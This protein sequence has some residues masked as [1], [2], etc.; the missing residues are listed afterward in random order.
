[1][2]QHAP[3]SCAQAHTLAVFVDVV[4]CTHINNPFTPEYECIEHSNP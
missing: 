2:P 3:S 4:Q 1:M